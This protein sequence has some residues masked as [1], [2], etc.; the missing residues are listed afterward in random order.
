[1]TLDWLFVVGN[2]SFALAGVGFL[3]R[4]IL[5]LRLLSI[6]S[7]LF[8]LAYNAYVP[9][10]PLWLVLAWLTLFLAINLTQIFILFRERRP[11]HLS[12]EEADL[13]A[14]VFPH[15]GLVEF[16]K[17]IRHASWRTVAAGTVLAR[18]GD[19]PVTVEVIAH[20]RVNA[21]KGGREVALLSDGDMIGEAAVVRAKPFTATLSAV[22]TTRLATWRTEELMALFARNPLLAIS[23]QNAFITRAALLLDQAASTRATP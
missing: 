15:L 6:S 7:G 4:D 3:A 9:G 8:G 10:G 18:E 13:R 22:E 17:L 14:G 23:F 19:Q 11:V 5:W 21:V 16:R 20:G 2:A 12:P 1:M